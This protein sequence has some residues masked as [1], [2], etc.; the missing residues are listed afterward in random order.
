MRTKITVEDDLSVRE[1]FAAAFF[2]DFDHGMVELNKLIEGGGARVKEPVD[3]VGAA[4]IFAL[5]ETH[6]TERPDDG[7]RRELVKSL[8]AVKSWAG[9][10]EE[11]AFTFLTALADRTPVEDLTPEAVG[12][13]VFV[14]CAWFSAAFDPDTRKLYDYMRRVL[15]VIAWA[16]AD[17]RPTEWTNFL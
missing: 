9:I 16:P 8:V 14:M 3:L 1:G 5:L 11:E 10:E 7:Q 17:Q 2:E 13:I 4:A 15:D 6:E 12:R